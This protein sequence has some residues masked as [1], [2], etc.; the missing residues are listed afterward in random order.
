M[1]NYKYLSN[2]HLKGF[3]NYKYNAID[4]SPLS[5]YVMHPF[6][7]KIVEFIP[8]WVAP[9]LITFVGF[10]FLVADFLLLTIYDYGFYASTT[11]G[12]QLEEGVYKVE[13]T[14][15]PIPNFVFVLLGI[16]LFIAYTLDGIDGKQA[17]KLKVS[18]PIGELFDHGL[19]SYVVFLVPVCLYSI[20][21]RLDYSIS[22]LRMYFVTCSIVFNFYASHVEKYN[23]G[24]LFLPWSYDLSMWTST[25][26]FILAGIKGTGFFKMEIFYGINMAHCMEVGI[27]CSA[28][29]ATIPVAISNVKLSYKHGTG[30]M[31]PLLE[32]IRPI[33][34]ILTIFTIMTFWALKSP[35]DIL[36]YDPR[37]FF[38]LFGTLF[39]S[40]SCRLIVSQMSNQR[41]DLISWLFY[42][43]CV[44]VIFS[45][46]DP[47]YETTS[48]YLINSWCLLAH[49]HYGT[50]VV[51]RTFADYLVGNVRILSGVKLDCG[52]QVPMY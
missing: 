34:S 45:F 16:F 30:K 13:R 40:V 51:S 19:D 20:F 12:Y 9:N 4:S 37:M 25:L 23:T 46:I 15:A 28:L 11:P 14:N 1:F 41:C 10:L 33:W 35:N 21:G 48:L 22:P 52:L 8:A 3:D 17:R 47:R 44:A 49:I 24:C 29:P 18:S 5:K 39:S 6:W 43:L 7:N 31:R 32:A 27:H 42:P 2:K 38:L 26:L 36:E 50:C